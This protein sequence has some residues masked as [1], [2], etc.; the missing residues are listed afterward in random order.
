M[1]IRF[2]S[3]VIDG[4]DMPIAIYLSAE[5][6]A[7]LAAMPE[8]SV[9]MSDY[10]KTKF[11][12]GDIYKWLGLKDKSGDTGEDGDMESKSG[13]DPR[14]KDGIKQCC[15]C[16]HNIWEGYGVS[17]DKDGYFI[18]LL[19]GVNDKRIGTMKGGRVRMF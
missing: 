16:Q 7:D 5:E 11:S 1:K 9:I 2:G 19:C 12:E 3:T 6:R 10:D 15:K 13:I 17:M 18:H 4:R 8:G 14:W